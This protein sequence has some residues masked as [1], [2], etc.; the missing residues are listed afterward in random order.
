[1]ISIYVVYHAAA[2]IQTIPTVKSYRLM[3][4]SVPGH[5]CYVHTWGGKIN[6]PGTEA[7]FILISIA[8]AHQLLVC[9]TA[10]R[11]P[12]YCVGVHIL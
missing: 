3:L 1:M 10:K 11:T 5:P 6:W 2:G 8:N 7:R 4:A 12:M 9:F